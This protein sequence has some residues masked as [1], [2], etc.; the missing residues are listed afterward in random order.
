MWLSLGNSVNV[1]YKCLYLPAGLDLELPVWPGVSMHVVYHVNKAECTNVLLHNTQH[2][3]LT[4][5]MQLTQEN[6]ADLA[7]SA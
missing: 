6:D 4:K 1:I 5:H 3:T 7:R 2:L